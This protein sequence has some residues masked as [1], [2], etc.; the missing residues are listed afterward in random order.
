MNGF[1]W[2]LLLGERYDVIYGSTYVD[3]LT[4]ESV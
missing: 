2:N 3:D 1:S 4:V